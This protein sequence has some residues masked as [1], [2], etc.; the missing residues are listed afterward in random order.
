MKALTWHGKG[1]VRIDSVAD[2]RIEDPG[3]I[4][5]QVTVAMRVVRRKWVRV[6]HAEH[7]P[8]KIESSLRDDQVLFLSDILPTGWMAAENAGIRSGDTVA[9]WGCGPVGQMTPGGLFGARRQAAHGRCVRKGP[10]LEDGTDTCAELS[11]QLRTA[12]RLGVR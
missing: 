7:G 4:L 8:I 12:W 3:D 6:P 10:D 2:P 5:L 11:R 9:V 1:D